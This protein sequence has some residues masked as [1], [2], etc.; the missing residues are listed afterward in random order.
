VATPANAGAGAAAIASGVP[1][2]QADHASTSADWLALLVDEVERR[3][4]SGQLELMEALARD[5][6]AA[7][8]GTALRFTH[9]RRI[10]AASKL[11]VGR[12]TITRK[13]QDLGLED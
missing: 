10:E 1:G 13:I 7:V 6:E 4:E 5:F 12:N 8:I 3:L 11:G 9:G 2:V